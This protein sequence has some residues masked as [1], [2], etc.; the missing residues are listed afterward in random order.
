[1]RI[2]IERLDRCMYLYP[3]VKNHDKKVVILTYINQPCRKQS[4]VNFHD[5]SPK[6]AQL[7]S[8]VKKG[9]VMTITIRTKIILTLRQMVILNLVKSVR[10]LSVKK[11][12]IPFGTFQSSHMLDEYKLEENK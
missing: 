12:N 6:I 8:K 5:D 2:N 4:F 11:G 7:K 9:S 1:M 10:G 3:D